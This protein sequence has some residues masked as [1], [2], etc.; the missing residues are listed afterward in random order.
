MMLSCTID[1]KENRYVGIT[2]ISG[3]FLQQA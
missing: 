3:A 2:D 1:A